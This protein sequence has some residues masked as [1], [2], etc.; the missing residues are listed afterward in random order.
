MREVQ[1]DPR[2]ETHRRNKIELERLTRVLAGRNSNNPANESGRL[3]IAKRQG[4]ERQ[5]ADYERLLEVRQSSEVRK[6]L[7][8]PASPMATVELTKSENK[9]AEVIQGQLRVSREPRKKLEQ[10]TQYKW[11]RAAH[12]ILAKCKEAIQARWVSQKSWPADRK[13]WESQIRKVGFTVQTEIDILIA[14]RTA[15]SAA[16]NI[17]ATRFS[18]SPKSV[19]N[20][21]SAH[22]KSFQ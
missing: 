22:K 19:Q 11:A 17:V 15:A 3:L 1:V 5:I 4:L 18:R 12:D 8:S 6:A 20:A 10:T 2:D 9:I 14:S 7:E 13:Q 16:A 21:Y